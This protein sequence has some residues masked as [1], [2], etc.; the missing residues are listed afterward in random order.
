MEAPSRLTVVAAIAV[1]VAA[2]STAA[3]LI[4][5]ASATPLVIA[6]WRLAFAVAIL[7]PAAALSP[8]V[9]AEMAELSARDLAALAGV[10]VVLAV[11]FAAWIASLELTSVAASVVLVTAHPVF[12]GLASAWLLDEGLGS[13]GWAGVALALVGA[14]VIAVTDRSL[15]GHRLVGDLLALVGAV[16]A[17][18]YFLAGRRWRKE[19][20]LLTYVVPV[21]AASAVTLGVWAVLAGD[22]LVGW[23][24]GDYVLFLAL[25]IV[26]MILG[27][28]LLNWSLEFVTAPVVATTVLGE[29][30]GAALIA[31]AVLA[32]V[33]PV[34]TIAGG[35]AVLAGIFVVVW[36]RG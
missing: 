8:S 20:G 4:R 16:A 23:P 5:L 31:W 21:Y 25:A 22:P 33:P 15:A 14:A 7:A 35:A 9:R 24:V 32:E 19:L 26:P 12:V 17:G 3:T 6:F 34:G 11:H 36:R 10:G 27:H 28:T 18:T 29:P 1:A 30:V 13:T 2:I